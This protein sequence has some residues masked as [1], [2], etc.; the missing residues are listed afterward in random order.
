MKEVFSKGIAW[1]INN[2]SKTQKRHLLPVFTDQVALVS[3]AVY[4]YTS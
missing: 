2:I 1:V 4:N 3:M